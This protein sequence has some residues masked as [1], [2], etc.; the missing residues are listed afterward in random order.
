[1][2][3]KRWTENF[4]WK[5]TWLMEKP[6]EKLFPDL[7]KIC[8]QPNISVTMA[9]QNSVDFSRW[10]ID[11]LRADWCRI[12]NHVNGI[13]LS[14]GED[15]VIWNLGKNE[16]FTVKSVYKSL[17]KNDVG[18]YFWKIWKEKILAKIKIFLCLMANNAI[19]T[20]DN[21]IR[22]KW[23]GGPSCLFCDQNESKF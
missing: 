17:T 1:M 4:F 19:L 15:S 8:S 18:P 22:R 16:R 13:S 21:L 12:M 9:K 23:T 20:R 6:L 10:L 2:I 11:D 5:D 3:V 7:F 14:N